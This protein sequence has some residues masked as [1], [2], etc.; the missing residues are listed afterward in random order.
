MNIGEKI[1]IKRKKA[2]LTQ[3]ELANKASLHVNAIVFYENDKR[4]PTITSLNKISNAL[5]IE[6]IDLI[7]ED[8]FT[9]FKLK[10]IPTE[11]LLKELL[12]RE[13]EESKNGR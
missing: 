5:K 7:A 4:S 8:D 13:M 6:L 2:G 9:S 3:S 12:R 1:K 11:R 10:Q